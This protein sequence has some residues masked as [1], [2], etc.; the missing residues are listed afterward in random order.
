[1][2]ASCLQPVTASALRCRACRA[3]Y[4]RGCLRLAAHDYAGGWF[5]C[6]GC[7][8]RAAGLACSSNTPAAVRALAERQVVVAGRAVAHSSAATYRSGRQRFV[9]FCTGTM[10]LTEE[11]ALPPSLSQDLNPALI[12][13]FLT[14][15]A[16][17][18]PPAT[19][20]GTL[21]ALGDWQRSRG[22][23]AQDRVALHP[24]V[25]QT[26]QRLRR[27]HPTRNQP[28]LR[29]KAPLTVPLLRLL[30]GRMHVMALSS[31]QAAP[32]CRRDACWLAIGFF[33]MLRRSELHALTVGDVS[34]QQGGA[35]GVRIRRSKN[36]QEGRGVTVVLADTSGS[37]VPVAL[38]V[39]RHLAHLAAA[40]LSGQ[41][42]LF[43]NTLPHPGAVEGAGAAAAM[44]KGAFSDRLRQLLAA[45]NEEAPQLNIRLEL[46][47]AHSL[48]RGGA[49]A[50][51]EAGVSRELI[52]A[53]GR[54]RSNAVDAYLQPSLTTRLTVVAR[55]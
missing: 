11:A 38:I 45:A 44:A 31:P 53:H 52:M 54:W 25:Q 21:T 33:G 10:G 26:M 43:P 47:A 1:M 14:H 30:I 29:S 6:A 3:A 39:Q 13:L 2:C 18:L 42:P 35:V 16:T 49:I 7:L 51:S 8:L 27:D 20:D 5:D 37:G 28:S 48:R 24:S 17:R 4:H 23:A 22:V 40:G 34:Q 41:A 46:F 15:S 55:M 50:A 19:L 12:C 32:V 36:D 9:Q